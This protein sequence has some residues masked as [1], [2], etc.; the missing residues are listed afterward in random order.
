[1]SQ[2]RD[3]PYFEGKARQCFR[4]ADACTD[5][6]VSAKL[7]QMGYEFAGEAVKL[8][9]DRATM[10]STWFLTAEDR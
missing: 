6:K 8:G 5:E 10:P 1:M 4:L 9:A 7:R 2:D 3:I